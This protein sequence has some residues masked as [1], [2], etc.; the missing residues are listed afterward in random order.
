MSQQI[1]LFNPIFLKQK[2]YFSTVAM[3]QALAV[4]LLGSALVAIYANVQ[5]S[6]L[7]KEA[8][9]S[10][11]QLTASQMQL[12]QIKTQYGPRQKDKSLENQVRQAEVEMQS[13]KQVFNILQKGD[14]GNTQGYSGYFRAFA[15]QIV[16]GVWLTN[17]SLVGAGNEIEL[18]GRALQPDMV[19]IY[20]NHLK[21]EPV[22]QGKSFGT[23]EMQVPQAAQAAQAAKAD[24]ATVKG[25]LAGYI[26]FNLR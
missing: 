20:M 5:V 7:R 17:I 26:E 25:G 11:A 24:P 19:P 1:N 21:R 8:A 13:L 22:M 9:I 15:R 10:T 18:H 16:D 12:A 4:L 2:K 14:M 6:A 3:A 23:L